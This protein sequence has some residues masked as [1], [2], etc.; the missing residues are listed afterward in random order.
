MH[1]HTHTHTQSHTHACTHTQ[2]PDDLAKLSSC[3][4]CVD[5]YDTRKQKKRKTK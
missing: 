5:A 1:T 3:D 2:P 4:S